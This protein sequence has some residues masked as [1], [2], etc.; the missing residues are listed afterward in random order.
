MKMDGG[1]KKKKEEGEEPFYVAR[2]G[3]RTKVKRTNG[4]GFNG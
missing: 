1:G 2:E 3:G 4:L